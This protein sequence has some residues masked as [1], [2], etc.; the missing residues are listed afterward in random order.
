MMKLLK[1]ALPRT[2]LHAVIIG[3]ALI[4]MLPT[5]GLLITSFRS[6]QDVAHTGW[7]TTLAHPFNFT[8]YTLHNYETVITKNGMGRA[9]I[10]S[11]IITIPS[12][13][14]PVLLAAFAAYAFA[15]MKFPG[16]K[17]L[18]MVVV[19]LLVIPLQMTFIPVLRI[20]NWLHLSGTFPGIWL[21]HTSYGLPLTV[22]LLHNFIA[23]LPRDLFDSAA[24]DGAS[25]LQT[26]FRLVIPLSVPAIASVVIFQFIW[27]WNDLLVALIYLGGFRSVAPLTLQVANLVGSRGQDWELL[28]AA[29][30]VSMALPL[31]VFFSL[32]RYFVRGILAGS[33]KG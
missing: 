25:T 6:P 16:R 15:W 3:I 17:T 4:W 29:A 27:V 7:W 21:A 31:F 11:L 23:G 5:V 22:Y 12:T 30:F 32:Q 1:R 19:A 18:F 2:T 33:V 8:Q 26:F 9:F 13:I 20:F 28:T 24:I 10:N 14:L